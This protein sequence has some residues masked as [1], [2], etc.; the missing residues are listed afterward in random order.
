ML[1]RSFTKAEL[2]INHLKHKQLPLQIDFAILQNRTLKPVHYLINY[3]EILPHKKHPILA[4]YGTDK[5]SMRI[6]DKSNNTVVKP[7]TSHLLYV[8]YSFPIQ[9]QNTDQKNNN[10]TSHQHPLSLNHTDITS[11]DGE[12]IYSRIP[13]PV[14]TF[15]KTILYRKK[16]SPL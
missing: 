7:S 10:K 14:S 11:E 9:I 2:Q 4:N 6:I 13:K 15:S 3:E 12:H 8:C 1:S 16:L 5:V